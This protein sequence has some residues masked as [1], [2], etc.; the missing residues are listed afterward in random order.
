LSNSEATQV[1]PTTDKEPRLPA[2]PPDHPILFI[3][4]ALKRAIRKKDIILLNAYVKQYLHQ[5]ETNLEFTKYDCSNLN[6]SYL[7]AKGIL[8][9][10]TAL[11]TPLPT[12]P[13]LIKR[14]PTPSSSFKPHQD[15][16]NGDTTFQLHQE[17]LKGDTSE[18][19]H[20]EYTFPPS[21]PDHPI[22][23]FTKWFLELTKKNNVRDI[24]AIN[25]L[26]I[27][28]SRDD[29]DFVKYDC[30]ALYDAR[31]TAMDLLNSRTNMTAPHSNHDPPTNPVS[32]TNPGPPTEPDPAANPVSPLKPDPPNNLAPPTKP[33]PPTYPM[34]PSNSN[35]PTNIASPLKPDPPYNLENPADPDPPTYSIPSFNTDPPTNPA[36]PLKPGHTNSLKPPTEP[37]PPTHPIPLSNPNPPTNPVSPINPGPPIELDPASPLKPDPP[38]NLKPPTTPD[39][40]THS[41]PPS[42]SDPPTYPTSPLKPD[43]PHNPESPSEPDPPTYPIPPLNPDPPVNPASPLKPYPPFEFDLSTNTV[44]TPDPPMNQLF[45]FLD[46]GKQPPQDTIHGLAE[47]SA[48]EDLAPDNSTQHLSAQDECYTDPAN[49]DQ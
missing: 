4:A 42:Y 30:A 44:P 39:P 49:P 34:P 24:R 48:A 43:P 9:S 27:T 31:R 8:T 5:L 1:H 22:R 2:P 17:P 47:D 32:L 6:A 40:P 20:Q 35:P 26:F 41:I 18:T 37:D 25:Q 11:S 14:A 12:S 21:P 38:Y 28:I 13:P 10:H 3:N 15:P 36:S 33:D 7:T 45:P 16:L 19:P 46:V 23:T 29:A